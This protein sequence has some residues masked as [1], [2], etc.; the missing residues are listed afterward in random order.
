MWWFSM[1][2]KLRYEWLRDK[3]NVAAETNENIDDIYRRVF[4]TID[5]SHQ[6]NSTK[7]YEM[8]LESLQMRQRNGSDIGVLEK[9]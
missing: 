5:I 7:N 3:A 1:C 2:G 8:L 6:S 4:R 9:I